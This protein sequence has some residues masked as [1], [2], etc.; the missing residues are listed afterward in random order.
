MAAVMFS[1]ARSRFTLYAQF[2]F[3]A[4]NAFGVLLGVIYNA[5][6]PDL[7]PNN[8]HHKL[9]WLVTWVVLA[10][11]LIGLLGRVAG[12][13]GGS[14]G[15]NKH[16]HERQ[17]FIPVSSEAMEEHDSR[18]GVYKLFRHS[19][20]SGHG[21]EPGSDSLAGHSRNHSAAGSDSPP[22]RDAG[23]EYVEDEDIDLEDADPLPASTGKVG[24]YRALAAKVANKVSSRGWKCLMFGYTFVDRTILILGFITLVTG[25]ATYARFFVS[26]PADTLHSVPQ[27][28][29][30]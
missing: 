28:T 27:L 13:R 7:Y 26:P 6:T 17:S 12:V 5:N 22:I 18:L 25:I 21:T 16:S 19:N 9:G 10:Q 23:K 30:E 11:V 14:S 8:A 29:I 15:S 3:V 1:L 2:V 24:A 20:D 4:A